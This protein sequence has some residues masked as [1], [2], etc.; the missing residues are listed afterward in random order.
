MPT[1]IFTIRLDPKVQRTLADM[2]RAYGLTNGR[3][4]AREILETVTSGD[5]SR[6]SEFITRMGERIGGQLP[7]SMPAVDTS[8]K[9]DARSTRKT[10]RR[11]RPRERTT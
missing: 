8:A 5:P 7:L 11:R 10:R 2:G 4:F 6:I 3:A 9:V 1:P